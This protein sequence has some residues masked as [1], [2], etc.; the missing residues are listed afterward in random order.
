MSSRLPLHNTGVETARILNRLLS[1]LPAASFEMETF[2]KLAG[3]VA[4]RRV[5]TAAVE[6]T[7]RPRL[8]INPDFVQQYCNRD[9]HL[10]LLVM[11]EL[12]HVLLAHTSLYPRVTRAQNIAF[13]AIINAGLMQQFNKPEYMGFFDRINPPDQFPHLLLRPP[14]GWPKN[15]Q[16]PDHLGPTGTA[17]IMRQL[18]PPPGATRRAMPFYNE[19]LELI[20]QDMRDRGIDPDGVVLLGDHDPRGGEQYKNGYLK[21]MMGRIVQKWPMQPM[22]P[23]M[24]GFGG[25]LG[26]W[27]VDPLITAQATRQ[28]FANVLRL[29]L[30]RTP[31]HYRRKERLPIPGISGQGVIPNPRDRLMSARRQLGLPSTIWAQPGTVKARV[32]ERRVQAHVYLDVSGSMAR[33]LPYLVNLIMPF[34]AQGKAD[35][36]QFSTQVDHLQLKNLQKGLVRTTGGTQITCVTDHLLRHEDHVTRALIVTDGY[37]GRP[38]P[39]HLQRISE[40]GTRIFIVLPAESPYEGDLHELATSFTILPP[41][42]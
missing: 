35:V 10:F 33:T 14:V 2:A 4:S 7:H 37:T 25:Q 24:P 40:N 39:E 32:P 17:R 1:S 6:C 18:Y 29:A 38:L 21:D 20:K 41:L 11:H 13:D 22:I 36:F 8:L 3:V 9:E 16:Y 26:D 31:G 5:P 34:V 12:W 19:I 23:G 28:A 15:P 42:A 30:A 27:Q